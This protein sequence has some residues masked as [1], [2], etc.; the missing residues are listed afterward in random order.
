MWLRLA[1]SGVDARRDLPP[2]RSVA[3]AVPVLELPAA[4]RGKDR[5][6]DIGHLG[7]PGHQRQHR[8]ARHSDHPGV[9]CGHRHGRGTAIEEGNFTHKLR[10]G[11]ASRASGVYWC[12]G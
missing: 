3:G 2:R 12:K 4:A 10:R 7:D 5:Y 1:N 8:L 6:D 9:F 11:Q